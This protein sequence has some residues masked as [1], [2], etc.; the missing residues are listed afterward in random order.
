MA[1][2][3]RMSLEQGGQVTYYVD[4]RRATPDEY[5]AAWELLHRGAGP[6][7]ACAALSRCVGEL[8]GEL[9]VRNIAGS[10]A[11]NELVGGKPDYATVKSDAEWGKR[12]EAVRREWEAPK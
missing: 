7:Q 6:C 9:G 4:D 3:I 5:H 11:C 8:E 10:R 2:A 12:V 1:S